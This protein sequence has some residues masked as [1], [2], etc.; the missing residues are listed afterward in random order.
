[1]GLQLYYVIISF[2]GWIEWS[3]KSVLVNNDKSL[4]VSHVQATVIPLLALVFVLLTGLFYWIL[5]R[6]T[7]SDV[8]FW[9]AITTSG[10]VVATW[11]LARKYIEHW[12]LW[13]FLDIMS[14]VLY[15]YKGLYPTTVLFAVYTIMAVVGYNTWNKLLKD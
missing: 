4:I 3:R 9:D 6:Y 13:I 5:L 8:P 12:L 2:Y 15:I 7:D 1:M 14:M 11:M 10:G